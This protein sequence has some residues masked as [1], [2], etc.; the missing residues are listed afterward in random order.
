[1]KRIIM[2]LKRPPYG[3]MNAAEAV[4]H[5]LGG[6]AD[7]LS[8]CLIL[9][10]GGV[11]LA[12]KG[13]DMAETGFTNLEEALKDCI[14]MGVEVHADA[15]SVQAFNLRPADMVEGVGITESRKIAELVRD[16][17]TTMLF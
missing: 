14:D 3:D 17:V 12:R 4:R 15:A 9:T 5:A 11:L 16:A 13:H 7:D 1:M 10:D 2:F 8:V 6:V